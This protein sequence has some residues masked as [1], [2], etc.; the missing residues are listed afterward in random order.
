MPSLSKNQKAIVA[1]LQ[2]GSVVIERGGIVT[3]DDLWTDVAISSLARRG[4][5]V[6][7]ERLD[8]SPT[9]RAYRLNKR[10]ITAA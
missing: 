8:A 2:D 7:A 1:A 4:I 5:L 6:R 9:R 3:T 10:F